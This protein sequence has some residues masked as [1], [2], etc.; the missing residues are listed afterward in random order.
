MDVSLPSD[1]LFT[2]GPLRVSNAVFAAYAITAGFILV[3]LAARGRLRVVP[4]RVQAAFEMLFDF[5]FSQFA[6][7]FGSEERAR[8][9]VPLLMSLFLF[10]LVANQFTLVPFVSSLVAEGAPVF[11]TPTTDWSGTLALAL[12][13]IG[14]AQVLS[15]AISPLGHVG[16]Y[17][18]LGPLLKARSFGDVANGLL[19]AFLGLLDIVGELAKVVSLSARLF[20]NIFAGEVMVAVIAALAVWT[21]F[22]VP[23][24]FMFLSIFSGLI[25]AFVFTLLAT[26]FIAMSV[27]SRGHPQEASTGSA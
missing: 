6:R 27:A 10:I 7:A 15:F 4:G 14:S 2:L 22:L 21:Q 17:L 5:L 23:M 12:V 19:Q 24:P 11:R 1:V 13:T 25:Q 3:A 16:Q 26:Q 18:R 20:G 8:R 9:F